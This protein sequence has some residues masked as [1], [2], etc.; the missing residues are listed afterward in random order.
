MNRINVNS[1]ILQHAESTVSLLVQ[2]SYLS[3]NARMALRHL[4]RIDNRLA[5]NI[6]GLK[7]AGDAGW[8]VSLSQLDPPGP[9]EMFAVALLAMDSKKTE[10][11][12]KLF[13]LAKTES[14]TQEGLIRS[15]EWTEQPPS[16]ALEWLGV[17]Q[18]GF[19]RLV[20]L[21][22][23]S[24][25]RIDPKEL[26]LNCIQNRDVSLQAI[27]LETIGKLGKLD[28]RALCETMMGHKASSIS[29][30]ASYSATLLGS[31][32]C[33]KQLGEFAIQP[34]PYQHKALNLLLKAIPL[35]NAHKFI[36]ALSKNP[37][38]QRAVIKAVGIA[39]DPFY[40]PWLIE[41]MSDPV[42]T[43][44]AGESFSFITGVD[45][46]YQDLEQKPP[47]D[48]E[49]GPNDD[50]DDPNV[51]L[52]ED[53]DLPWPDVEKVTHWW[54]QHSKQFESGTRYFMGKPVTSEHCFEV[55][56]DGFQRQRIAAAVY[57]CLLKPG[58]VLFPTS[59]PAW[60]QKELLKTWPH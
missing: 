3:T 7:V 27:S 39:G 59:A 29:F 47:E 25:C 22:G 26:L 56:K 52:D 60:R 48:F 53:D 36:Q 19:L 5:A 57:L 28:Q 10:A 17:Q 16:R 55:L 44:L 41:R 21:R 54:W 18:D 15:F 1:V 34:G 43:R 58:S 32:N 12:K 46:A 2:R 45:L 49:S 6:D 4:E 42:F 23:F 9:G 33:L 30:W 37:E 50:P 51:E 24:Q 11:L 40:I 20:A 14:I 31:Q 8:K 38:N 13:S 35:P